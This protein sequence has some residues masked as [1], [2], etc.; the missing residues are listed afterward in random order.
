MHPLVKV[1]GLSTET[2]VF[3]AIE[4]GADFLGFVFFEKSP[5]NVNI[6]SAK[7]L[8]FYSKC[9]DD[10]VKTVAVMVDPKDDEIN[11]VLSIA[12]LKYIQLHGNE[13]I[14][15]VKELKARGLKLIKAFGVA[16]KEDLKQAEP[17]FDLVDYVLFDAK[18]PKDSEN[19]GG[20]GLQF[21]WTILNTLPE[22]LNWFLSGGLNPENVKEAI[23][24]TN[25][26]MID[27]SSGVE[28]ALGIKDNEKIKSFIK[29]A[30]G[31]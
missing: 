8:G 11:E 7:K 15:R 5:R 28:S 3:T 4:A 23:A 22:G 26:K 1:C 6:E 12:K 20:H 16:T 18:P 9:L 13:S 17:Y 29:A 10:K 19:V 24:A 27:V 14:E 31:I 21:D 30:K 25:A 2:S